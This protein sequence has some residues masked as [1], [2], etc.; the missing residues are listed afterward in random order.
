MAL[1]V[2]FTFHWSAAASCRAADFAR[3]NRQAII[4]KFGAFQTKVCN[5][6]LENGIDTEQIRLFVM[7]QFSPGE[8][9]PPSPASLTDIFKAITYHGLWDC[10]HY[11]P[12][13]HIV[14]MFGASDDDMNNW[15]QTYQK[16]LKAYRLVTTVEDYIETDLG[17]ADPPSAKDDLN[18]PCAKYDSQYCCPVEWKTNF[19]DH[20]LEYLAEVW[21]LFSCNYLVPDSPPTAL[22]DRVRK[23][24]FSVTW[25]VPSGLIST[26]IKT[27]KIDRDFFQQYRI[28]KVT[29]GDEC[30]YEEIPEKGTLVSYFGG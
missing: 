23:G 19:I 18:P 12:L 10:L 4:A 11:S 9:I 8:C 13:V 7:N 26:L 2:V 14:Q 22:L 24:C 30:I 29:V 27:V 28:L 25:L 16:D 3:E 5:K 15:V 20:S 1:L 6:L 21:K 17:A